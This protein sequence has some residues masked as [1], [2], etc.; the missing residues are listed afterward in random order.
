[1]SNQIDFLDQKIL[2][3]LQ[4][5]ARIAYSQLAKDLKVSNSLIHQRIGKLKKQGILEEPV[6]KINPKA[7]GYSTAAYMGIILKESKY[8]D[9]V[10]EQVRMIPEVVEC[11]NVTGKY[12]L[13]IKIIARD[14]DHLRTVLYKKVHLI[15]EIE[16]TNTTII[17]DAG[18][19]RSVP[20]G[21]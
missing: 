20:I 13:M 9:R 21:L 8:V 11:L 16:G 1:M 7:L 3:A 18:F 15:K 12:A 2:K 17:F 5:D 6:F 19:E 4:K 10:V 14:N